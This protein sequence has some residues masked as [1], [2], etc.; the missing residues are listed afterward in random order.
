[1]KIHVIEPRSEQRKKLRVCAYCRVSTEDEELE[2]SLQNQISY[3][4]EVIKSNPEY[5]FKG[6][7]YDFGI[8][9]FK[10]KRPEFQK[11]LKEAKAGNI[12]LI[13]T[14]SV[15]R[16][17]RNTYTTLKEVR[18]LKDYGV[19]IFFELQN[20]YTLSEEGEVLITL[21]SAFAQAESESARIGAKM[22]YQRKYENGEPVQYLERSFGYK[23]KND[24]YVPDEKEAKWVRKIYEMAAE[25]YT[26]AQITRFLNENQVRTVK[27]CKFID[28]TV[29]RILQNE[30]Y[31]GDYIMHKHYV[32]EERKLVKNNGEEDA[33]YVKND[34]KPIVNKKLWDEAQ[35]M[36]EKKRAY[37]D[38]KITAEELTEENY[39]YKGMIFCA[40]CGYPLIRRIYSNGN[41]VSWICSGQKRF[42]S[43]FCKGVSIPDTELKKQNIVGKTYISEDRK[44]KG[45][46][47]FILIPE[48]EWEE[49]HKRK[50]HKSSVPELNEK[51]YPYKNMLFCKECGSFLTRMIRGDKVF[52]ICNNYKRKGKNFCSGVTVP[53]EILRNLEGINSK[54]YIA[55]EGNKYSFTERRK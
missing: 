42:K 18:E 41:R 35:K 24:E 8:S 38:I 3:Y 53:D 52:W 5:E 36:L 34:H 30:I 48:K 23:K 22:V 15:S 2:N 43:R 20:I 49:K 19:G 55:K 25:G 28:C 4:E 40:T 13:I 1:M 54:I 26:V 44:N 14:K 29:K 39:P 33:W 32:N 11:M 27:G 47:T 50:I 17:A 9:G 31:K 12:D 6:V 10:E 45:T 37:L 16:F 46:K 21:L 7:Y 51:N